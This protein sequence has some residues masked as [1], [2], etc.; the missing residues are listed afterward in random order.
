MPEHSQAGTKKK[1][2]NDPAGQRA[3]RRALRSHRNP[4]RATESVREISYAELSLIFAIKIR[5]FDRSLILKTDTDKTMRRAASLP[6]HA[7]HLS[8]RIWLALA[9][10]VARASLYSESTIL[11]DGECT[12]DPML[13]AGYDPH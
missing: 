13:P 9:T 3:A 7:Q 11:H 6:A 4:K 12:F 1:H 2:G 8:S 10:S 5:A